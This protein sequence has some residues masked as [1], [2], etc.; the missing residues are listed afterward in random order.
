MKIH[1]LGI[2]VQ[3]DFCHP[4]GNLSVPGAVEDSVRFAEFIAR[5]ERK[6]DDIHITLDSHNEVDIAHPIMWTNSNGEHPA[7]FT[8]ISEQDVVNGVWKAIIPQ[9]GVEYVKELTRNSKKPLCIW[10]PHCII[11]KT[12]LK[13][14][15][16]ENGDSIVHDR[17][18]LTFEYSGHAVYEPISTALSNWAK[19][20]HKT[21]DY[22]VKG[23]NPWTE[24]Y[25]AI[26]ADVVDPADP[27]TG[28]NTEILNNM[29]E[30]D[31]IIISGQARNFCVADTIRDVI[32]NFGRE[33][34]KKFILLEDCMSDVPGFENLGHAFFNDMKSI[35]V[36][37]EN[38]STFLL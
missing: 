13:P 11:G 23:S 2:D 14:L 25:S 6:I 21:V 26:K 7:P 10:P 20:R 1:I 30:A 18:P 16:D 29:A 37:I 36:R 32:E 22:Q 5:N 12:E 3:N 31:M 9:K 24:H 19:N 34:A 17:N 38:S 8:I 28:L 4:Q 15:L 27:S 35:G 33:Q